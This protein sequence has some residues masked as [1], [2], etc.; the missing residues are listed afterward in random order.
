MNTKYLL[1]GAA[2][3]VG[4]T[5]LQKSQAANRLNFFVQKVNL[6]F[7]GLT[8]V[9][10]ILLGV[11]N[12]TNQVL[13][14]RSILGDM[15][16]DGSYVANVY[17]WQQVAIQPYRVTS[18]PIAARLSLTGLAG[19]VKDIVTQILQGTFSAILNKTVSFKGH[20]TAEGVSIPLVFDYKVL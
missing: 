7:E 9:M 16:I 19:Q 1:I 13:Y 14:V 5:F 6:R 20:V 11:Q 3:F 4:F 10:E 8:P 18:L 2:A 12:P 17:G 15:Y